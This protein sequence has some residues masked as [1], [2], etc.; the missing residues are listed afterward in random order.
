M[1]GNEWI[2]CSDKPGGMPEES[3]WEPPSPFGPKRVQKP[4]I[5]ATNKGRVF[6]T[7]YC[8]L[9]WSNVY[10][11]GEE[12]THFMYLPPLPGEEENDG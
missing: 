3:D 2:K 1:S 12:V 8:A 5:V 4:V 9:G 6:E 11:P 7:I 10:L